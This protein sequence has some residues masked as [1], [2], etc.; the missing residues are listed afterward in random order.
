MAKMVS[1][2]WLSLLERRQVVA[3]DCL[4]ELVQVQEVWQLGYMARM[5]SVVLFSL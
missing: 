5:V 2:V 1:D 3:G 4:T